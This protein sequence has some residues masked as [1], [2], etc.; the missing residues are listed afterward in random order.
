LRRDCGITVIDRIT[1]LQQYD[2]DSPFSWRG[3]VNPLT[4]SALK[5]G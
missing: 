4:V 2:W 3:A 1:A 5:K